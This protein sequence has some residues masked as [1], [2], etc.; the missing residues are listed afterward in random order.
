MNRTIKKVSEVYMQEFKTGALAIKLGIRMS[1][2]EFYYKYLWVPKIEII[3]SKGFSP[4][5]AKDKFKT[6]SIFILK[7]LK[8]LGFTGK[9]ISEACEIS[10]YKNPLEGVSCTLDKRQ[11][12]TKTGEER[13][14]T[15]VG[16]INIK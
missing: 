10:N 11:F 7:D 2:E 14:S 3:E 4:E 8:K 16:R 13:F 12:T 1:D 15:E 5:E 9:T 6:R